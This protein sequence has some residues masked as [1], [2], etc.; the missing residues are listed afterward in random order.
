MK[1]ILAFTALFFAVTTSAS[2]ATLTVEQAGDVYSVYLDGEAD[3]FDSFSLTLDAGSSTFLA[4]DPGFEGFAPRPAGQAFSYVN[5]Y[6]PAAV[7]QGGKGLTVVGAV[8]TPDVLSFDATSLT[9][10]IVTGGKMF[11]ANVNYP[12]AFGTATLR[13]VSAGQFTDTLTAPI[14]IPEPATVALAGLG[15]IGLVAARRRSA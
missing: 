13:L 1:N 4:Q 14:G 6:L 8:N 2:A 5:Q 9:G 10:P 15:L 12:N 11:L 3:V 7:A